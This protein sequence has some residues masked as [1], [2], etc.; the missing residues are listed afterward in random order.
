[1]KVYHQLT[2]ETTGLYNKSW[3]EIYELIKQEMEDN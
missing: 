1:M 3:E 2:D